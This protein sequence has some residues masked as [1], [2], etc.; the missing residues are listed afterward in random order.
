LAAARSAARR[1]DA[2][3][4]GRLDALVSRLAGGMTA[5]E[6]VSLEQL[7]SDPIPLSTRALLAWHEQ[8][9]PLSTIAQPTGAE[10]VAALIVTGPRP[11]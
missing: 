4:L 7:L 10:L 8:L 11:R 9:P 1:G 3:E 2:T 5:G 6:E